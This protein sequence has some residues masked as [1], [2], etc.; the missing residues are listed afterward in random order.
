M[1]NDG[2]NVCESPGKRELD[3]SYNFIVTPIY[4]PML[5]A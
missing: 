2:D 4:Q 1:N 5:G 3:L